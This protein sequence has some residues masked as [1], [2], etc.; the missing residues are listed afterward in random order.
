MDSALIADM[1]DRERK[2]L[3]LLEREISRKPLGSNVTFAPFER[4]LLETYAVIVR[5]NAV[6][7]HAATEGRDIR[8]HGDSVIIRD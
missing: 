8:M 4:G 6:I 7:I 3:D 5:D 2:A 1:I